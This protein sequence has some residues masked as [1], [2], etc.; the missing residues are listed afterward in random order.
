MVAHY[1]SFA[2]II[3]RFRSKTAFPG[4]NVVSDATV[5][6]DIGKTNAK[7]SLWGEQ[8]KQLAR[9][10]RPNMTSVVHPHPALDRQGIEDWLLA[11]LTRYAK[12]A[13]VRQIV[14]VGHGA[15]AALI[16]N[17]ALFAEPM[18]YEAD[19]S[20]ALRVNY[21]LQRDSFTSTGSPPLPSGLNLGLQLHSIEVRLG[22][23]LPEDVAILPWPQYWAWRLC[24]I[25]ASE[26]TSLGC[27]TDLWRPLEARFSNLATKRG[28]ASR[29]APLRNKIL[30]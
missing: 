11:I 7:L 26:V 10:S 8:G 16:R 12:Q 28:W 20:D 6:I 21:L 27:H 15:A 3:V 25:A 4:G 9:D 5:I 13:K 30:S 14:P 18:D 19:I 17:G 29:F 1:G 24:G 22:S 2:I 23:S